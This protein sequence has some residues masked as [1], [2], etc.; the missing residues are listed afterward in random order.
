MR[1]QLI[2]RISERLSKQSSER[3]AQRSTQQVEVMNNHH[4]SLTKKPTLLVGSVYSE[5]LPSASTKLTRLNHYSCVVNKAMNH[6][7]SCSVSQLL[8]KRRSRPTQVPASI[9]LFTSRK[10]SKTTEKPEE[11][12]GKTA[13]TRCVDSVKQESGDIDC[14]LGTAVSGKH[15]QPHQPV[16]CLRNTTNVRK[17]M[18]LKVCENERST[19]LMF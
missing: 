7:I 4:M 13:P 17:S 18:K 10:L 12:K 16:Y 11:V 19:I 9:A 2:Q 1:E 14:K 8:A 5:S 3:R 6:G 15:G